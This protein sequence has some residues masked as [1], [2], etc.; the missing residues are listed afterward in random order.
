MLLAVQGHGVILDMFESC[1]LVKGL[2]D[3]RLFHFFFVCLWQPIPKGKDI[4]WV[5]LLSK[6]RA[7]EP[8]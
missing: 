6:S 4:V 7:T 3:L 8:R 2:A 1:A 5:I